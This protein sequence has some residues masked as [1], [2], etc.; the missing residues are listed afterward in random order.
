MKTVICACSEYCLSP[1][2]SE[3]RYPL[4]ILPYRTLNPLYAMSSH[5]WSC[6]FQWHIHFYSSAVKQQQ[7]RCIFDSQPSGIQSS[8]LHTF[9]KEPL[10]F[11]S[12]LSAEQEVFRPLFSVRVLKS[13]SSVHYV[14]ILFLYTFSLAAQNTWQ[15]LSP[16]NWL[17]L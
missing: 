1:Y 16:I 11:I 12:V 17:L 14:G 9:C 13:V 6:I 3:C 15:Y 4:C 5:T 2:C 7:Y 8:A 10:L